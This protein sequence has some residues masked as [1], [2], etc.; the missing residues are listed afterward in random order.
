MK[1]MYFYLHI[2]T[3]WSNSKLKRMKHKKNTWPI[4]FELQC[5]VPALAFTINEFTI[6][7]KTYHHLAHCL[8][9]VQIKYVMSLVYHALLDIVCYIIIVNSF[10]FSSRI[11]AHGKFNY[12]YS[13]NNLADVAANHHFVIHT[14]IL[15]LSIYRISFNSNGYRCITRTLLCTR[16]HQKW[17]RLSVTLNRSSSIFIRKIENNIEWKPNKNR[18]KKLFANWRF[19]RFHY[20][21]D[22]SNTIYCPIGHLHLCRVNLKTWHSIFAPN[23]MHNTLLITIRIDN[24][25]PCI[26]CIFSIN[27]SFLSV[28]FFL[29]WILRLYDST[30]R[31]LNF[32]YNLVCSEVMM[33]KILIIIFE[34]IVFFFFSPLTKP[35]HFCWLWMRNEYS[36]IYIT[37]SEFKKNAS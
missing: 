8:T 5:V 22:N 17:L 24:I 2:F 6:R 35:F 11:K 33:K 12:H 28:V 37:K 25:I 3:P 20:C 21:N 18:I 29:K 13:L 10:Q 34:N 1:P 14:T 4:H 9:H 36:F 32:F 23:T 7:L 19:S 26:Q 30:V 15:L 31:K 27:I 16:L